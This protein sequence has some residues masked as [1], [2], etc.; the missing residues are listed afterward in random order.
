MPPTLRSMFYSFLSL[1]ASNTVPKPKNV[2]FELNQPL[3]D[4][5]NWIR[6]FKY[7]LLSNNSLTIVTILSLVG[8]YKNDK[9]EHTLFF[10]LLSTWR[11]KVPWISFQLSMVLK[12]SLLKKVKW[13]IGKAHKIW[14]TYSSLNFYLKL[15]LKHVGTIFLNSLLTHTQALSFLSIVGV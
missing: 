14:K 3:S 2:W 11:N 4:T 13:G 1:L 10:Y 6:G 12:V 8:I 5:C 9:T 15:T 7:C